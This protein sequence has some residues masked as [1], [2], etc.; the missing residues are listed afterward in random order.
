MTA[1]LAPPPERTHTTSTAGPDVL[2]EEARRR[3]RRRWRTGGA[4][5]AVVV[6]GLLLALNGRG[7]G[8]VTL[9]APVQPASSGAAVGP[10]SAAALAHDR[11]RILSRSPVGAPA[12]ASVVWTGRRLIVL[13]GGG[14]MHPRARRAA[15]AYDP[16]SG[17]WERIARVPSRVWADGAQSVWTGRRLF[18]FGGAAP[19]AA[20]P[21]IAGLYDP[22]SNRWTL[23]APVPMWLP[24]SSPAAAVWWRGRVLVA[25]ITGPP[26]HAA[27]RVLA[28]APRTNRWAVLPV[29]LSP[30]HP[31]NTLVMIASRREV[32]LWSLWSRD[33]ALGADGIEVRSGVDVLR[34]VGGR[35]RPV[36][37]RWPQHRTIDPIAA[38]SRV[39][40]GAISIWCGATCSPPGVYR[41]GWSADPRSLAITHLPPG[42]LD[43]VGPQILWSGAAQI[44]FDIGGEY[45]SRIVTGDIAFLDLAT[46]HWYRGPRAPRTPGELP[47]VWDGSHL[48]VLDR[49]GTLLSYGP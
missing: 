24:H 23:T 30:S 5:L 15:A 10:T 35:W 36:R 29:R 31:P 18:V 12:G 47:A 17:R 48:L 16:A 7:G 39:L 28:Y 46:R 3:R 26:P 33:R 6:A 1:Q 43:A 21:P 14:A 4:L 9:I 38:G 2:F 22:S 32:L 37:V 20:A 19:S 44:A 40:F 49:R 27:A 13:G 42:P 8:G 41:S 34:L 11:W 45:G 25:A